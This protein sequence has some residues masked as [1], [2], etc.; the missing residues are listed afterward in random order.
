M[1]KCV[2]LVHS[3][4]LQTLTGCWAAISFLDQPH[5]VYLPPRLCSSG[6]M[7]WRVCLTPHPISFATW[8]QCHRL[9]ASERDIHPGRLQKSDS[10]DSPGPSGGSHV[11]GD[12]REVLVGRRT[13]LFSA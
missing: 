5:C 13:S 11:G 2:G 3:V 4:Y 12:S 8:R 9:G 1:L 7:S 10:S 6:I